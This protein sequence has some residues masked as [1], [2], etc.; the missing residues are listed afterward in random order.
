MGPSLQT[1]RTVPVYEALPRVL[2]AQAQALGISGTKAINKVTVP[3][4][5]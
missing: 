2:C 4:C 3:H 1:V 5:R